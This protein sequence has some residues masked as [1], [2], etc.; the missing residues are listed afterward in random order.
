MGMIIEQYRYADVIC[1]HKTDGTIIPIKIRVIDDD[2]EYQ[3]YQ[4][5]SYKDLTS[6]GTYTMPNG[7]SA[8]NHTWEFECKISIFHSEKRIHLT[9]NAYDNLWKIRYMG[10]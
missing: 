6:Y 5:K 8:V 2:G 9:Y 1:Q 3:I 10:S 4:I 7:V